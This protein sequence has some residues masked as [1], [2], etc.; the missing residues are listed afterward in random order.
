MTYI[1]KQTILVLLV[2]FS[3]VLLAGSASAQSPTDV[4]G[5]WTGGTTRGA[6]T[7]VLVLKQ[8][9][10][11][12]KGTL[13]G[14][15]TDDGPVSGTISGNAI[16]LQYDDGRSTTPSLNVKGDQITGVLSGGSEVILR[17]TSK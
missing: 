5:T 9:G 4:S 16:R 15:G 11:K 1:S 2:G 6:T 3:I 7:L 12:V 13:S 8:D 10:Q 17:R 14:A